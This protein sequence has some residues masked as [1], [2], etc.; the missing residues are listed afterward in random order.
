MKVDGE[1]RQTIDLQTLP[2]ARLTDGWHSLR[3]ELGRIGAIKIFIDDLVTPLM[4]ALDQFYPQGAVG[5]GSFDDRAEFDDI[6]I[7]GETSALPS[8]K[9]ANLSTR[10]LIDSDAKLLITGLVI[11]GDRPPTNPPPC[12]RSRLGRVRRAGCAHRSTT[13]SLRRWYRRLARL[14]QRLGQRHRC[15]RNHCCRNC[16]RRFF[17]R[18]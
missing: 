12:R 16:G 4:T 8:T 2:E 1:T 17:I 13:K 18:E 3:L 10:G 9:L 14:Q 5:F 15:G 6:L 7:T 11:A